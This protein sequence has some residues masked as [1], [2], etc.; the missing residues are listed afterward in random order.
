MRDSETGTAEDPGRGQTR[1]PHLAAHAE[2]GLE[3][4]AHFAVAEK[5]P[6][7]AAAPALD[8]DVEYLKDL[9]QDNLVALRVG[10][11]EL[12]MRDGA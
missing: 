12:A 6:A 7:V 4:L 8:E 1:Q 5:G 3:H 11:L 10:R 2:P 9:E